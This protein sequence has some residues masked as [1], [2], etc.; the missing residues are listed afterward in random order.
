MVAVVIAAYASGLVETLGYERR[1][2]TGIVGGMSTVGYDFGLEVFPLAPGQEVWFDYD[3]TIADGGLAISF[4]NYAALPAA[5]VTGPQFEFHS[6]G[7]SGKGRFVFRAE[8][9]GLY[10]VNVRPTCGLRIDCSVE[11]AVSWGLR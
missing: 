8:H 3:A 2:A 10:H 1:T 5:V 6:L 9:W 4:S 11:Y 7:E